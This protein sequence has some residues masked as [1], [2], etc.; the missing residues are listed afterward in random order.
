VVVAADVVVDDDGR[1]NANSTIS[2]SNRSTCKFVSFS[3]AGSSDDVDGFSIVP[4]FSSIPAADWG[5][6]NF[7]VRFL[8]LRGVFVVSSFSDEEGDVIT[9]QSGP[10]AALSISLA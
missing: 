10:V 9:V 3:A 6:T 7:F 2:L 1:Y 4:Q 8:L 5:G